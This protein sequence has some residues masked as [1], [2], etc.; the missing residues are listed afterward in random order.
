MGRNNFRL[1]IVLCVFSCKKP[2]TGASDIANISSGLVLRYEFA[3]T[4][5]DRSGNAFNGI[6]ATAIDF[7]PDRFSRINEA[8]RFNGSAADSYFIIPAM[9][10]KQIKDSFTASCWFTFTTVGSVNLLYKSDIAAGVESGITLLVANGRLR[11]ILGDGGLQTEE[12]DGTTLLSANTWYHAVVA[13]NSVAN[14]QVYLNGAL[15]YD[16]KLRSATP[17]ITAIGFTGNA[18]QV[19]GLMGAW[20]TFAPANAKLDDFRLYNRP[21]TAAEIQLLYHYKP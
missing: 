10:V 3:N 9:G 13:A 17:V 7:V 20:Q 15:E 12:I 21:L 1:A 5:A 8:V 18:T 19:R 6:N 2:G 16:S 11:I 4:L 14:V